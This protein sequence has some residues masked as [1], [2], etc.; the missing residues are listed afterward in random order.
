[1]CVAACFHV[2]VLKTVVTFFRL[3][4]LNGFSHVVFET[5]TVPEG[6]SRYPP[7]LSPVQGSSRETGLQVTRPLSVF[8]P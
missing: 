2:M 4:V 8:R 1:M 6:W 7:S 3:G 5:R